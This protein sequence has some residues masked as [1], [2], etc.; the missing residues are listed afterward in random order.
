MY[1]ISLAYLIILQ[2]M[3]LSLMSLG[4]LHAAPSAVRIG[5]IL[6]S[7]SE[8]EDDIIL[9]ATEQINTDAIILPNTLLVTSLKIIN[10]DDTFAAVQKVCSF[11]AANYSAIVSSTSCDTSKVIQS[12]CEELNIPHIA[13]P[14]DNCE[15]RRNNGFS[16]SIRP[17]YIHID[18][19]VLGVIRRL[20]WKEAIIFYDSETAYRNVKNLL[21]LAT[22]GDSTLE[23]IL[24]KLDWNQTEN[25]FNVKK[26]LH[27]AKTSTIH[28]YIVYCQKN[29]NYALLD[30]ASAFG[31]T[32]TDH[33]WIVT[34]QEISDNEMKH[35]NQSTGIIALIRQEVIINYTSRHFLEAWRRIYPNYTH[36]ALSSSYNISTTVTTPYA[37]SPAFK[38]L[39]L[40]LNAGYLY[41]AIRITAITINDMIQRGRWTDPISVTCY[42]SERSRSWQYGK[43]FKNALYRVD[44][45]GLLGRIHFN[46]TTYND[47]INLEIVSLESELNKTYSWKI[48]QWDPVNKLN[49][50][51]MPFMRGAGSQLGNKSY[52]IVTIIEAPFVMIEETVTGVKYSGYC[53][54]MLNEIAKE[55]D[56]KYT[57]YLTPDDKYGGTNDDGTWNGLIGQV[58]YG[59]ADLAVAGMIINSDRE[60]VVDF[61]KPYMSYG[62][63]ILIRK[64]SKRTNVFAFL[65][66]LNIWVWGCILAAF[67]IVGVLLYV[68]DRLSPY[69]NHNVKI[70]EEP[71]QSEEF[72]LK[73]SLWFTFASFM[74]QG[75]DTTPISLSGRILSAFWWFFALIVIATYTANLAAFLTVTRMVNPIQSLEDLAYQTKVIYGTIEDSSL[76]TFF[77]KRSTVG[78]YE[79]MWNYMTHVNPSPW[80]LMPMLG[81]GELKKNRML[82]FGMLQ[83]WNT[84][85]KLSVM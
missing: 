61:T 82:S 18:H 70:T 76:Q 2:A 31:M 79:R 71:A 17:N 36:N 34:T 11:A 33:H 68:L 63:G 80:F 73:N 10:K 56:F 74:Q 47:N 23:V 37:L 51:H 55:L 40:N 26:P 53:I 7:P 21:G 43:K 35:F 48:G 27:I 39:E 44:S 52:K 3:L 5:V 78:I 6:D 42:N 49:L 85:N 64:P 16:L 32:Q 19:V 15:I 65:E 57:L 50:T 41:D 9:L 59:K 24:L 13:V 75:G 14:R 77:K 66:P 62:V 20:G 12:V 54:D 30:Q 81:T 46:G 67:F 60:K 83:Y 69:S 25:N 45:Q 22:A 38:P 28:N 58:Y 1:A 8:K 29:N 84:L 4:S 72:D